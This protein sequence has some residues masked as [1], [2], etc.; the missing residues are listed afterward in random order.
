MQALLQLLIQ[1]KVTIIDGVD[2]W[3]VTLPH[4]KLVDRIRM[5]AMAGHA[6]NIF[7]SKF[8]ILSENG[9]RS[10]THPPATIRQAAMVNQIIHV[11]SFRAGIESTFS[12]QF[13]FDGVEET[14]KGWRAA[15]SLP[16]PTASKVMRDYE[17]ATETSLEYE[18]EWERLHP[19]LD[20]LK[21]GGRLAPPL[22]EPPP[23]NPSLYPRSDDFKVS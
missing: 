9:W 22:P 15:F 6:F 8:D 5:A 23:W 18:R 16:T 14:E 17:I 1:P 12:S 3:E 10:E 19:T 7:T 2:R 11:L 13:V 21:R 20:K 4:E